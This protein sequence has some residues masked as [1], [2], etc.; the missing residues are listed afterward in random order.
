VSD[1]GGVPLDGPL[2]VE[3]R[4]DAEGTPG[5]ETASPS[6]RDPSLLLTEASALV[7]RWTMS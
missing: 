1:D 4:F 5:A 6:R 7:Q 3:F 2:D